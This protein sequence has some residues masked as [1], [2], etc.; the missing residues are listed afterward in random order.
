MN[1]GS[2]FIYGNNG[3]GIPES[4]NKNTMNNQSS[5]QNYGL[6]DPEELISLIQRHLWLIL[7]CVI[8][9]VSGAYYILNYHLEP[10]YKSEGTILVSSDDGSL[11]GAAGNNMGGGFGKIIAQNFTSNY[12]DPVQSAIYLFESREISRD[13][14]Q[15]V[16]E[17][18]KSES[19]HPYPTLWKEFP[20]DS[21]RI[22]L[23]NLIVRIRNGLVVEAVEPT[24]NRM[25]SNLLSVSFESYS[26]FEAAKIVNIALSSY[27]E[28]TLEQKQ[29]TA[30]KALAFLEQKKEEIQKKLNQAEN[31]LV[32][33]QNETNLVAA[34][35]QAGNSV[36][37]LSQLKV[38]KENLQIELESIKSSIQNFENQIE[39]I[40]PGMSEQYTKA[41]GPTI[42]KYQNQLAELRTQRFV[43]LT[44]NPEL[45]NNEQ[46]EPELRKIN[47]QIKELE[48]EIRKLSDGLVSEG[49]GGSMQIVGDGNVAQELARIQKNLIELRVQKNQIESQLKVLNER[50][51]ETESF[52]D[53]FPDNQAQLARLQTEVER[54]KQMHENLIAQESEVALWQ[55]TQN[56]SGTVID[57]ARPILAPVKPNKILWLCFAVMMGLV[58]PIGSLI[59]KKS[60]NTTLNSYDKLKSYPYP[61]LPVIYDH[62]LLKTNGSIFSKR[63]DSSRIS[64]SVVFFHN[65]ESPLAEAYRKIVNQLLYSNPDME[66]NS[67]LTTSSGQGEGKTTF[68]ANLAAAFAEVDKKVLIIDCDFRRPAVHKMF[69]LDNSIGVKEVLF[70]DRKLSEA[71]KK[72][73]IP[74]LE[75][76]TSGAKPVSPA[77]LLASNKFK[78]LVRII[79]PNYDIVLFDTPPQSL[80]S[81][82]SALINLSD[83]VIVAARFGQTH[84]KA[85]KHTLE[86]IEVNNNGSTINLA[87]TC[88]KPSK[89][90][91]TADTKGMHKYMYK[92]YYEYEKG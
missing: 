10:I 56:S 78:E 58:L 54:Y 83:V 89:S 71:I 67:L 80:V 81:D 92:K 14:A 46:S 43:L 75:V 82:V 88:Y 15:Q 50:I 90:Y 44:N 26:P 41:L 39:A 37:T 24:S 73:G 42:S 51:S 29:S 7:F 72:T 70:D 33:F 86:E 62:S 27:Q 11:P 61:L 31:R 9:F 53:T 74:D 40:R 12:D 17:I 77:K 2:N 38:E 59:V 55:Q 48:Q 64:Q 13:I 47:K 22:S 68:T 69:S 76:L 23:D 25:A 30:N 21:S 3:N 79:K 63:G 19:S 34:D 91:D 57:E 49:E 20:E 85:L 4:Q 28:K 45:K 87:L 52:L 65:V 36:N 32:R 8:V 18:S 60:L 6:L 66:I 35:Q 1:N 16:M 84:E 5:Y